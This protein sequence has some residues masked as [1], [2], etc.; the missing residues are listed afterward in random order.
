MN[1]TIHPGRAKGIISAPSSK[2]M[3]HRMLI[4]AGLSQGISRISGLSLNE[5]ILATIDCLN[6]LGVS[7]VVDGDTVTVMGIDPRNAKPTEI[8]NCRESGST[9]R[10]LMPLALLCGKNV[11]LTGTE[12]LLSR[13]LG[14]YAQLCREH[15]FVFEQTP[16]MVHVKGNLTGGTYRLPG[17]ISSQFIT[18][19]LLALP[20][21][22]KN[23]RIEITTA[24]ESKSYIDLTLQVLHT[25]GVKA[26]WEDEKTICIPRNQQYL[27][28][29]KTVEGD[30]SG[31]AFF[32][33][34]NVLGSDVEITGLS[35]DSLQG[36]RVYADLFPQLCQG[37]PTIDI[38]DCPDLG[39][40]LFAV[41]AAKNGA[42]FTGTHRLKLKESDR[43]AAMAQEL[44][45]FG[46]EVLAEKNSVTINPTAFHRPHRV[47]QSHNDHRIVMALAIL[48]TI[49]GG[50]IEGAEAVQKSFPDFFSKLQ[51]L[52]I[53]VQ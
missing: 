52:G 3:A 47:L 11:S 6:T 43:I 9:L 13:P 15:G 41:A 10:F 36:D 17:N 27:P 45:A 1:I 22:E 29:S 20:L 5:D 49:T 7:C 4:C 30:Y 50:E 39:P 46:T 28:Q 51:S 14:I 23:S 25:F 24:L 37:R 38:T 8:L 2:S 19:L 21:T 48:L 16:S 44:S 40:I 12:K 26:W 32:A 35:P 42:V 33:A 53:Q 18:G 34:L 31:A